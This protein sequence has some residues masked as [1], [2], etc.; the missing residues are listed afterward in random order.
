M[1]APSITY[2]VNKFDPPPSSEFVCA[3]CHCVLY[4]PRMC[5]CRHIFCKVCIETWFVQS[6]SC[7]SCR[8]FATMRQLQVAPPLVVNVL[9]GLMMVCEYKEKGCDSTIPMERFPLHMTSC[10]YRVRVALSGRRFFQVYR[11]CTVFG[12]L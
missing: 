6:S 3:V 4:E 5:I 2:D 11:L 7:P 10:E 1:E 12:S 8:S 9:N